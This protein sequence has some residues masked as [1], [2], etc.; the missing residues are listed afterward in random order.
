MNHLDGR[1]VKVAMQQTANTAA[2]IDNR[3]NEVGDSVAG[4][5][6]KVRVVDDRVA[7]V[8]RGA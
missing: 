1:E 5:D 4:V 3:V 6:D 8:S 2:A 7:E